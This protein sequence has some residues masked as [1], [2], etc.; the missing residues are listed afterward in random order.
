MHEEAEK[1][2]DNRV[3]FVL[4]E[5]LLI[6]G[7]SWEQTWPSL[8][9]HEKYAEENDEDDETVLQSE[10]RPKNAKEVLTRHGMMK[11]RQKGNAYKQ[12]QVSI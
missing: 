7:A 5:N 1:A 8:Q 6:H 9:H 3:V 10:F 11:I 4:N 12:R 2:N